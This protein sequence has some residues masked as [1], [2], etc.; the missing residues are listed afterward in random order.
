[1]EEEAVKA[2]FQLL[3]EE[4]DLPF[5]LK[6]EQC[7]VI[8]KI[9]QGQKCV[10]ILPTGYGK[11]HVLYITNLNEKALKN[12]SISMVFSSPENLSTKAFRQLLPKL[13][14]SLFV[15]DEAH[16]ISEWSYSQS[17]EV[18]SYLLETL[19]EKA[20]DGDKSVDNRVVELYTA[21]TEEKTKTRIMK[22]FKD[23]EGKIKILVA[24][25]AFGMGINIPDIDIIEVGRC[26]RDG[27]QGWNVN[28][29]YGRSLSAQVTD[30]DVAHIMREKS[31]CIRSKILRNFIVKG[32]D[33]RD[34]RCM[35]KKLNK[36]YSERQVAISRDDDIMRIGRLTQS[37]DKTDPNHNS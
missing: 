1:M 29:P 35:E 26:G 37:N 17:F 8:S 22:D 33:M 11:K 18:W 30:K 5:D 21:S 10:A 13:D 14:C 32:M 2:R 31:E 7:K 19:M 3:K 4:F 36:M 28:Y 25:I 6:P 23:K 12:G 34:L 27:R 15:C 16:C 9:L 20:Y 24:T